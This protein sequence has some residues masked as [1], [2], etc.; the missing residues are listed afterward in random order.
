MY[1][2]EA[3]AIAFHEKG[4]LG[5][6]SLL[7]HLSQYTRES[8]AGTNGLRWSAGVVLR[9][10]EL[11]TV[12]QCETQGLVTDRATLLNDRSQ[13]LQREKRPSSSRQSCHL[14]SSSMH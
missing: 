6:I 9:K 5:V 1:S 3:L 10:Q 4:A 7:R 13:I 2:D 11:E 12:G 14:C 8:S